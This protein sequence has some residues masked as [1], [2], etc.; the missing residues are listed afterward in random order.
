MSTTYSIPDFPVLALKDPAYDASAFRE[1]FEAQVRA[2]LAFRERFFIEACDR[3]GVPLL[4]A[5]WAAY[6]GRIYFAKPPPEPSKPLLGHH[7]HNA[8]TGP[9]QHEHLMYAPEGGEPRRIGTLT[10]RED[11]RVLTATYPDS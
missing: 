7:R 4:D 9:V 3:A 6:N 2:R 10:E 1:G 5:M 11:G 8:V